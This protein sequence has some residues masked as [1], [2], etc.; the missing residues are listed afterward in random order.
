MRVRQLLLRAKPYRKRLMVISFLTVASSLATLAIPWL[1][2]NLLGDMLDRSAVAAGPTIALLVAALVATTTFGIAAALV[3]AATSTQI[4]ADLR[5][6][7]HAHLQRLPAD[8]HDRSHRGELLALATYDVG[9]LSDF[10]TSTLASLPSN[11]LSAAGAVVL[12]FLIDP[13]L[14]LIVPLVV[15]VFYIVLRIAGRRL[16]VLAKM[17]R[18]AEAR[19]FAVAQTDL[20][21][22]LATK[23]FAVEKNQERKFATVVDDARRLR[24]AEVRMTSTLGPSLTLAASLAAIGL[25]VLAGKQLG[26]GRTSPEELFSFLLYAALLTRP[27]GALAAVYGKLQWAKGT[28]E[29]LD[30]VSVEPVEPNYSQG[31]VPD[32]ASQSLS[33]AGV[34][35]AYPD[36]P[37]VLRNV[38]FTIQPGEIVAL[39]G[40]NGAGK[41]TLIALLLQFYRPEAGRIAVGDVDIASLQ[42]QAWRRLVGFVPQKPLLF[43]GTIRENICYGYP[44]ATEGQIETACRLAQAS[45]FIDALP[46]GLATLIGDQGI[47]LSGGQRQRIALAR[48]LLGDPPFLVLDEA[49][50]MYD[51]EGE[52]A[53][54]AAC[55]T[56]LEGRTVIIVTHRP[57]SL[58]L[59]SRILLVADRAVRELTP[60]ER[61]AM[62]FRNSKV[63]T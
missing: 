56:G 51:L 61:A 53:F 31:G 3:T 32:Q 19:L 58:A 4:L 49:T 44:D 17:A 5:K 57:A 46:D 6:A 48:A 13:T 9:V 40:E 45:D 23:S 54:V 42:V 52:A 34:D 10:M 21:M 14:A 11:L 60:E 22:V 43:D 29:R 59:A 25:I 30:A 8:F 15:P 50:S 62:D 33:F 27:M 2:A 26:D 36:R 1:A 16:R 24:L 18:H 35:F 20:D 38:S 39:V 41:S 12:L 37:P 55:R 7:V 47:R 63:K 28:L